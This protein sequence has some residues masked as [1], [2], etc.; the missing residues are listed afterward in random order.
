MIEHQL[1]AYTDCNH[2]FGLAAIHPALYRHLYREAPAQFARWAVEVWNVP[3]ANRDVEEVAL[4]GIEALA[5][6]I[7]E[8]GLPTTLSAMGIEGG[9]VNDMLREV[10]RTS[11]RTPACAKLLSDEEV[12]QILQESR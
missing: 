4:A 8:V 1:G 7:A 2:G 6:F 9:G 12:Y 10:A 11:I 5:A 3:S